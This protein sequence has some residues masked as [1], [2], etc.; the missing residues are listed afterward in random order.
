[1]NFC[2]ECGALLYPKKEKETGTIIL[3]C[4]KCGN[5][6][7]Q[8]LTDI[9]DYVITCNLNHVNREKIGVIKGKNHRHKLIT[10]EE[11]EAFEDFFEDDSGVVLT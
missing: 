11:R 6:V 5:E 7:T 9:D 8:D 4:K 3:Y 10:S 1:M 2:N